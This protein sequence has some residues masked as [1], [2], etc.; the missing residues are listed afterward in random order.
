MCTITMVTDTVGMVQGELS[1]YKCSRKGCRWMNRPKTCL[2]ENQG[3]VSAG[4]GPGMGGTESF[5]CLDCDS[6]PDWP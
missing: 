6:S 5:N 4:S 2:G 1:V 3:E